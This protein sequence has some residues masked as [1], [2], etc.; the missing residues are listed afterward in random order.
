MTSQK[1]AIGLVAIAMFVGNVSA[2]RPRLGSRAPS[3]ARAVPAHAADFDAG[4]EAYKRGD[5]AT[6]LQIYRQ[7]ADQGEAAAQY[8]LGSCT[9]EARAYHRTTKKR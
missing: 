7:F 2:C 4:V 5:Y 8:N 1:I 6:A 9:L 3:P